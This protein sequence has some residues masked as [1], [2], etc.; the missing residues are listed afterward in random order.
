MAVQI[1]LRRDT[2]ANWTAANPTLA[3]G[4]VGLET[5]TGRYKI[6]DGSTSWNSLAYHAAA[7]VAVSAANG[8]TQ[9]GTVTFANSNGVSF[10]T[11]TQGIYAT[12]KTDYLTTARASTDAVGLNT[13]KTNV[14]WTVNSSGI[15]LDGSGYAGTGTSATNASVTLNSNGLQ[16]SVAGGGS[17]AISAG[18]SSASLNSIVF[19]NSNGV[20]FGLNGSTITGSHNGLT[21]QSNQAIS[22][23]N[24]SFT[25]QTA[26]FADSN[27]VSF[28]TG[29]QGI[30]ATV[31]TDYLTTA[32]ASNDAVGLN[33]AQTNVTWTVNSSGISINAGGYAGTGYT[34]TTTGGTAI[35]GTHNTAGLSIGVPNFLTT[36]MQSN[37]ATISNI[38]L[39]AGTTSNNLSAF[40][41]SNSNNVSFGL[42]GSTLTA[43]ALFN[44]TNQTVGLYATSNTTQ[45][46]SGTQDA[47]SITFVGAG[48]A[49]VGVSNGSVI[50]S[51]PTGGGAGDGYNIVNAGT[52]GTTGTTWSS[53]SASVRLNGGNN[54]TISQNNS[55]DIVVS[56]V[57][58]ANANNVTFGVNAGTV[59]ASVVAPATLGNFIYP[60]PSIS[61]LAA[62]G[63]GSFSL[64][65][66]DADDFITATRLEM[67]MLWQNATTGVANTVAIAMSM[68][69]AIYTLN[70]STLSSVSSGS[71]QTTY[72]YASNSAGATQITGSAVRPMSVPMNINMAPSSYIIGFG[73]STTF[74]SIGTATT[75]VGQTI[76]AMGLPAYS[77][78]VGWVGD[79]TQATATSIG[80]LTGHGVY[81][82]AV[83]S[84]VPAISLSAINYSGSYFHRANIALLFRT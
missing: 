2:A 77:S 54:I 36:A 72:S 49:S 12:V 29:T 60:S 56:G 51:V 13:A 40:V 24:G 33:T 64:R 3:Q 75:T 20:S 76:S 22:A 43:T 34:S 39:S 32:R 7:N 15:S 50:V 68:Y 62:F 70:G 41:A 23:A 45:S 6:G 57:S 55:N 81:S 37:A 26:T 48:I 71:T 53:L 63:N 38:N 9:W 14:T 84:A 1:Q 74:S 25:F 58:F 78:A 19:S 52:A 31:K 80:M 66:M 69:A 5:D 44:Q 67:P 47:R 79:F 35:V 17:P 46:S 8:S 16:I 59:T 30:Y 27:G 11:G 61:A 10:S 18:T 83:N 42:N 21:S 73:V 4:E 82:A 28:S 65:R